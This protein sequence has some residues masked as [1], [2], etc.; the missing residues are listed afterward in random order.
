MILQDNFF[1]GIRVEGDRQIIRNNRIVNTG[2]NLVFKNSFNM[3][4]EIIGPRTKVENNTVIDTHAQGTGENIAI[5][6]SNNCGDSSAKGNQLFNHYRFLE[7]RMHFRG[8]SGHSFGIWVG[9]NPLIP[10][11]V[12]VRNN[13]IK[14]FYYG[15]TF[16]SPTKGVI[17]N[18]RFIDV[19]QR[20][21][22]N[23]TVVSE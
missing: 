3:G 11:N 5:S 14:N 9:G 10:S 21:Y 8:S 13:R 1:R 19:D 18:N 17:S 16:S 20:A 4:I 7:K 23:G 15:I 6:F 2:G 12:S 22:L